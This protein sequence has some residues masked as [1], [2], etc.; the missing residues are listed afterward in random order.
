MSVSVVQVAPTQA[1]PPQTQYV[2]AEI[3]GSSSQA[4]NAQNTPQYIVVTVTGEPGSASHHMLLT[5]DL[6]YLKS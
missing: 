2:T 5:V 6:I 4:N 1:P 3:Q